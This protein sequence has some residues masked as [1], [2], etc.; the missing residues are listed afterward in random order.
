MSL[1]QVQLIGNLGR[2]PEKRSLNSGDP[3]CNFSIATSEKWKDKS[4]GDKREQTEWHRVVVFGRLADVCSEYLRKGSQVF[5]Q[6]KLTTRKWTDKSGVEKYT[7]EV[8]LSGPNSIMRMI[9][10]RG[11]GDGGGGGGGAAYSRSP[12]AG[13]DAGDETGD[14]APEAAE[15]DDDIPF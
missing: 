1:N 4:T 2:D 7:T 8:V 6:G 5:I 9:G 13:R 11:D 14:A 3:V 10:K 12:Y 15:Y